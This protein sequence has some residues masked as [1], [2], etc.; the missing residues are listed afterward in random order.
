MTDA[1]WLTKQLHLGKEAYE[2]LML[3]H[4]KKYKSHGHN[5]FPEHDQKKGDDHWFAVKR[6]IGDFNKARRNKEDLKLY[7][8]EKKADACSQKD[9]MKA[10]GISFAKDG[11]TLPDWFLEK[12]PLPQGYEWIR[13]VEDVRRVLFP[14]KYWSD[15]LLNPETAKR[16]YFE[17]HINYN[18]SPRKLLS[19]LFLSSDLGSSGKTSRANIEESIY[20]EMVTVVEQDSIKKG[21]RDQGAAT[22]HLNAFAKY[23]IAFIN[24]PSDGLELDDEVV[25]NLTDDG[26]MPLRELYSEMKKKQCVGSAYV[27]MNNINIV[28]S[29][30][31]SLHKRICHMKTET[32][33]W[34][35]GHKTEMPNEGWSAGGKK[36]TVIFNGNHHNFQKSLSKPSTKGGVKTEK[37]TSLLAT[38]CIEETQTCLFIYSVMISRCLWK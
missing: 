15:Y 23:F 4:E 33:V 29:P 19:A 16:N 31:F 25:K 3:I 26:M 1:Y 36:F 34:K 6:A 24:D 8:P 20:P 14:V 12:Y 28:L 38:P 11:A 2:K 10:K 32:Y 9:L 30:A 37:M 27:L 7:V 5:P 17:L 22:T 18:R 13:T 21:K 35:A